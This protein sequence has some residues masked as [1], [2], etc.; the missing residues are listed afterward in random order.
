MQGKLKVFCITVLMFLMIFFKQ[1]ITQA[2][3]TQGITCDKSL[4]QESQLSINTK[5]A[6]EKFIN[7]ADSFHE[8]SN[9]DIIFEVP[10]EKK[11]PAEIE[12]RITEGKSNYFILDKN[13]LT[14]ESDGFS[15]LYQS[16][17]GE[18]KKT[19]KVTTNEAN[20]NSIIP[21][22]QIFYE[23][24]YGGVIRIKPYGNPSAPA[25]LSHLKMPHGTLY[26][27]QDAQGDLSW[28][29]EAFK[30]YGLM[31]LPKAP[32]EVKLP[33]GVTFGTPEAESFLQQCW[34]FKTHVPLASL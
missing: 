23:D 14:P 1:P 5:Q 26:F 4:F 29:N 17:D 18:W 30:V 9:V 3:V 11:S 32:K 13:G 16:T 7:L 27:K 33:D 20:G 28:S 24:N 6:K 10:I 2:Q 25:F 12:Q 19:I 8:D 21:Y 15:Q 31:P 34:T 22:I